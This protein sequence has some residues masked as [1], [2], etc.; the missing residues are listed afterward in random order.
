MRIPLSNDFKS[1]FANKNGAVY[2]RIAVYDAPTDSQYYWEYTLNEDFLMVGFE[3]L[4]VL[5]DGF[6]EAGFPGNFSSTLGRTLKNGDV[7]GDGV[8]NSKDLTRLMKFIAGE[9]LEI[10][11]PDLNGDGTV[12]S[13][14][15]VHLIRFCAGIQE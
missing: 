12:N 14:D 13:K 7:N 15:L 4:V 3:D 6:T 11:N 10:F 9:K 8:V 1:V 2:Y 5:S